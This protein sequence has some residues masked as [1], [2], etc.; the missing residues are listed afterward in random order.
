MGPGQPPL[1]QEQEGFLLVHPGTLDEIYRRSENGTQWYAPGADHALV[2][3]K[4][5]Q[6]RCLKEVPCL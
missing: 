1:V 6:A 4:I 5:F 2:Q 3:Q